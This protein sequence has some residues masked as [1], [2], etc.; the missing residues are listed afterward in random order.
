MSD[1]LSIAH[2]VQAQDVE[3]TATGGVKLR[4]G[5]AKDRRISVE[6]GEMRHGRSL[7]IDLSEWL[8]AA[9]PP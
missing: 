9:S 3:T 1:A 5:V 7:P 6:E 4:Q 8:Q 2:Q